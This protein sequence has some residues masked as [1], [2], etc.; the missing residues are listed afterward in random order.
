RLLARH[1]RVEDG[2]RRLEL[3]AAGAL[4]V[5]GEQRLELDEPR[6]LLCASQRLTHQVGPD[7]QRLTQ[8][9]RHYP[10]TSL[11]RPNRIDSVVVTRSETDRGPSPESAEMI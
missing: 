11:G 8:W 2:V 6:Q 3:A 9:H 7:A 10:R 4:Q 5:A 1:R